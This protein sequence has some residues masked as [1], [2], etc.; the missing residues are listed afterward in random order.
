VGRRQA[1][2][3]RRRAGLSRPAAVQSSALVQTASRQRAGRLSFATA[4]G[5]ISRGAA[6]SPAEW[7]PGV[8]AGWRANVVVCWGA[9]RS[10]GIVVIAKRD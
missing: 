5:R 6:T 8:G 3:D 2:R 10:W 4:A 7:R 9:W 1:S